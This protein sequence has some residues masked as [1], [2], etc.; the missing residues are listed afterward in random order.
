VGDEVHHLAMDFAID[1]SKLFAFLLDPPCDFLAF[2]GE[3]EEVR[4]DVNATLRFCTM[5]VLPP[6]ISPASEVLSYAPVP[7][8]TFVAA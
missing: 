6:V 3:I 7:L 5:V 2:F 1:L 8:P 4:C